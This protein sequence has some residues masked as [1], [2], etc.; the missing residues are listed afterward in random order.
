MKSGKDTSDLLL[1]TVMQNNYSFMEETPNQLL[2]RG[3]V[4]SFS[5]HHQW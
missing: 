1:T 2:Q 3:V 4:L 5:K